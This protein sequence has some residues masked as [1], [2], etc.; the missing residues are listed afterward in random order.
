[1]TQVQL[2]HKK[3]YKGFAAGKTGTTQNST[4]VWFVGYTS[5]LSTAIWMGY[6]S[7]KKK[8]SGAMQYGGTACAPLWGRIMKSIL[9]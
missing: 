8:L 9:M 6:D 4:D 5:D 3:Y 1:L 2:F 7:P